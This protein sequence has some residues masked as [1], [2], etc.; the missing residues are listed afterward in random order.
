MLIL[1]VLIPGCARESSPSEI[2]ATH[3]P[4]VGG[5]TDGG[6]Q[7]V[8]GV[9]DDFGAFCTGTVIS[10]RTVITAGHCFGGITRVYFGTR[11]EEGSV[12]VL[13]EVLHPDYDDF[14]LSHDLAILKLA[15]NFPFQPAPLLREEMNNSP[16]FIGPEFTFVGYGD[17]DA[18]G[19]GFGTR[20][21]VTFPISG[22]GPLEVGGTPGFIDASQFYYLTNGQQTCFGDSGGPAFVVRGGVERH[23][24]STSF[25]DLDCSFDGVQARTDAPLIAS[26]IQPMIDQFEGQDPCR[27]DG[28]CEESCNT[29]GQL[30]D[31]DC[32]ENHCGADGFCAISCVA[33]KDPDCFFV[34]LDYCQSD[35]VCDPSCPEI[36]ED[37]LSLCGAEGNCVRSC[38]AQPDPD[39]VPGVCG[40]GVLNLDEECDDG[41]DSDQ[42]G[43]RPDCT[44]PACGDGILDAGEVCDDSNDDDSDDCVRCRLAFCGDGFVQEGEE[45]CDDGNR[46]DRDGCSAACAIEPIEFVGGGGCAVSTGGAPGDFGFLLVLWGGLL[47]G[48]ALTRERRRFTR[49]EEENKKAGNQGGGTPL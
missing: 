5:I 8:V 48:R 16:D 12:E 24:G 32:A 17:T 14:S 15:Q 47:F 31:P 42:D 2:F 29:D 40:D 25:G 10:Q 3:R 21:V 34:A 18:F 26:F 41:N 28:I 33:P 6:H 37:C 43:C 1:W 20:R 23:A 4:I 13:E 35:G 9:G 44:R 27:A 38:G 30:I 11:L 39:C 49:P 46:L 19:N 22:V 7:Y 36:D 45:E